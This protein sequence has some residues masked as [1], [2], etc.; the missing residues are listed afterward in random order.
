MFVRELL[1]FP[2]LTGTSFAQAVLRAEPDW[3]SF[4]RV[5]TQP[6]VS[7]QQI[8]HPDLY[9]KGVTPKP[10]PLPNLARLLLRG[11]KKLDENSLG[12]FGLRAVLRQYLGAQRSEELGAAWAGDRYAAFEQAAGARGEPRVLLVMLLRLESEAAAARVFGGWSEVL[13]LKY[14]QRTNLLRRPNF[15]SFTSEEGGVYLRCYA[16]QCL[17]VEGAPREVFD[18][19][20]RA[21]DW[22]AVPAAPSRPSKTGVALTAEQ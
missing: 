17:T 8:Y 12:E 3:K 18:R 9:L 10:V 19:I 4:H 15:F 16:D 13:E 14:Q 22:P 5:F 21:L 11:W 7:T 6:P 2:Y 1:L 20:Q